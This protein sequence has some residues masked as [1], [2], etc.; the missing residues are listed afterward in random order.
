MKNLKRTLFLSFMLTVMVFSMI[1]CGRQNTDK[2]L[3]E[4]A[5]EILYYTCGMH[6]SVKVTPEEYAAGSTQCPICSM[7]LIAVEKI[8]SGELIYY[9]C[10]MEGAEHV[11]EIADFKEGAICPICGMR[12]KELS[13]EEADKLKGVVGKVSLSGNEVKRA[14]V[15]TQPVLRKKEVYKEIRTVGKVAYDPDLAI[16]QEEFLSAVTS[17]EKAALSDIP[18]IKER[19]GSLVNSA[20]RK[21]MLLGLGNEQ[22][23]ELSQSG[24]IQT[25]LVLPEKRMWIYG[26]VYEYEL[27]WLKV[28]NEIMATTSSI[29]G[30][31]FHGRVSSINPV[32][33]PKTRSV[34]FR[35]EVNNPEL[36]LKPEM[37]VDVIIKSSIG[38]GGALV[39][40][41]EAVLDTGKRKIVWVEKD[42]NTFEGR[43]VAVGPEAT[44]KIDNENVIVYPVIKGL[45][46]GDMVVTKANFLIDSQSKISGS[47][48]SAYGGAIGEERDNESSATP[49]GQMH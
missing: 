13:R 4:G 26:D 3:R 25:S 47:A 24:E 9:G 37:Y 39:V 1:S 32:L 28:G 23:N 49:H 20:R 8:Q 42:V 36:K 12:L 18:E 22:I 45:A 17:Y 29:P 46:E 14:G 15:R 19:A 31:M 34:K 38:P 7:N 5:K 21:L 43:E 41:K 30:E 27:S 11:Y 48:Q 6:P 44:V 33:D 40:P 2:N 35:A 10:G 16:A